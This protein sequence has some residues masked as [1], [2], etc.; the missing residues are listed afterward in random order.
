[1]QEPIVAQDTRLSLVDK[2]GKTV[3]KDNIPQENIPHYLVKDLTFIDPTTAKG[4]SSTEEIYKQYTGVDKPEQI[5]YFI[6]K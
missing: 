5:K 2:E 3:I 1:V 6:K 4:G